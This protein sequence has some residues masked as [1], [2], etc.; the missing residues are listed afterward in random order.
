MSFRV[1]PAPIPAEIYDGSRI[2]AFRNTIRNPLD[3]AQD[4]R[5]GVT[6]VSADDIINKIMA[7]QD[8]TKSNTAEGETIAY[9]VR[10]GR[11]ELVPAVVRVSHIHFYAVIQ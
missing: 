2:A 4:D 9:K 11:L 3:L 6:R 7:D 1:H 8:F 10:S 5:M